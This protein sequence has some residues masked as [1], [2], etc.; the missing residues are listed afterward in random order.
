MSN[1]QAEIKKKMDVAIFTEIKSTRIWLGIVVAVKPG[2]K[3][4]VA[5]WFQRMSRS[6]LF[7]A[8]MSNGAPSTSILSTES[9]MPRNFTDRW[10]ADS[11]EHSLLCYVW[12]GYEQSYF[13]N[14]DI[15][16]RMLQ[17]EALSLLKCKCKFW[18]H[19]STINGVT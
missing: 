13:Q 6:Q 4:F 16:R 11:S 8:S 12:F 9:V 2:C 17:T 1:F 14:K 5:N 10:T 18:Q 3:V 7:H 19:W 15:C